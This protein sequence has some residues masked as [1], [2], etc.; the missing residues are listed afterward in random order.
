[1][2]DTLWQSLVLFYIPLFTYKDSSIDIWSMGSLWTISV[3]ILVNVHLAM[4]ISRWV[5]ISHLAVWGSIIITYGCMVVLDSIPVFPN[6]W[7][8]YHLARSPTYWITILL[9]IMVALLPRFIC[10]AVYQIFWPSDIRIAREAEAMRQKPKDDL[11][12]RRETSS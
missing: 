4:D 6:Y 9:I 10:K 11:Q 12:S 8:I 5:L 1:M 7:T 3:V 2:V